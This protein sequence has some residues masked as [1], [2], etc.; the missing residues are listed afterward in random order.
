MTVLALSA[1]ACESTTP[2]GP[3]GP[4]V[5]GTWTGPYSI[6]GC[7]TVDTCAPSPCRFVLG[8]QST[9]RLGLE[10]AGHAVLGRLEIL[11]GDP[12]F[13]WAGDVSGQI[14]GSGALALAGTL[15]QMD[16]QSGQV[17]R[18]FDVIWSTKLNGA[19][20]GMTGE[21]SFLSRNATTTG[22]TYRETATIG[23]MTR[24]Q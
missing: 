7:V 8:Q 20:T 12:F 22:C 13:T 1:C 15:P 10:Q 6:T 4:V 21:F 23:S 2:A 19:A 5:S 16:R 18:Y 24:F 9:L 14:D 11:V 3:S 17:D